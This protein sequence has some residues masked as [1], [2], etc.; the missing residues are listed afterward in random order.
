MSQKFSAVSHAFLRGCKLCF[1]FCML[2]QNSQRQTGYH[3]KT[4]LENATK[5]TDFR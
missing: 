3:F 5:T 2:A 1:A 4:N